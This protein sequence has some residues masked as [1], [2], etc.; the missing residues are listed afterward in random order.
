MSSSC[1]VRPRLG[2][3]SINIASALTSACF[4][5]DLVSRSHHALT[6]HFRVEPAPSWVHL[7]G[8]PFVVSVP[9][10]PGILIAGT[11]ITHDHDLNLWPDLEPV[12]QF[13]LL[14][15]KPGERQILSG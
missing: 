15:L 5:R 2:F 12:S 4:Y 7:L 6:Q 8:N 14:P 9:E 10:P 1:W 11:C 13:Q 3:S